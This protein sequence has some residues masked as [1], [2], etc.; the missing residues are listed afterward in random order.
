[1]ARSFR[2]KRRCIAYRCGN[3]IVKHTT[4][5]HPHFPA[6]KETHEWHFSKFKC[7]WHVPK[8]HFLKK[9]CRNF[10]PLFFRRNEVGGCHI[11]A[12]LGNTE[13][14]EAPLTF[15]FSVQ[16]VH[17]LCLVLVVPL[18]YLDNT[19]IMMGCPRRMRTRGIVDVGPALGPF[20]LVC[21][22]TRRESLLGFQQAATLPL[23][24]LSLRLAL[25]P[26]R[27]QV[28]TGAPSLL[29]L[30]VR[31]APRTDK[32][33]KQSSTTAS[34]KK[35]TAKALCTAKAFVRHPAYV[36]GKKKFET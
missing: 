17:L 4:T 35:K 18:H 9:Q 27:C 28:F 30:F 31:K 3:K 8:E 32:M 14:P 1:M 10:C 15:S 13:V 22:T 7:H 5:T 16:D 21:K 26:R 11:I 23:S 2:R 20:G 12:Q 24:S 36:I 25:V 6:H 19:G 33:M 34:K 29:L